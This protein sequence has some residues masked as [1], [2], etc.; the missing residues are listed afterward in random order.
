[1]S[2]VAEHE[3]NEDERSPLLAPPDSCRPGHKRARSSI[4]IP[5]VHSERSILYTLIAIAVVIS[6]GAY[7]AIIPSIRLIEDILCHRYYDSIVGPGHIGLQENIDEK[8]CKG[9]KIQR[10]LSFIIGI[11]DMMEAAPSMFIH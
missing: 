3:G 2:S 7:L 6:F 5:T 8:L 9:D 10:D 1:M 11:S 4:H